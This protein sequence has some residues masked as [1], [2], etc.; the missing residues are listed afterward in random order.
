MS[1]F[2]IHH[3]V[4]AWVLAILITFAGALSLLRLPLE[5]YP[6][7]APPQVSVAARYNGASADTV[8]DSVTQINEQQMK[9]LDGLMY[10][11]SCAES[12][13]QPRTTPTFEPGSDT[14]VAQEQVQNALQQA[15][16]RLPDEVQQ[17]GV[18]VTKGGQENLVT[19]MFVPQEADV[20]RVAITDYLASNLV[21]VLGRIDGVA[22]V[23]L[24]GSPYAMR[25]WLD[26]YKLEQYQLMP[27]DVRSAIERQNV[28]VSAGQLGQLPSVAG[29]MLNVPIQARG[30]LQT[31]A[32]FE[33]IILKSSGSGARSPS[34]LK[35]AS[36][37]IILLEAGLAASN[38]S[39]AA[40]SLCG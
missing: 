19:W 14:D 3:P 11:R 2:F 39:S 35:T 29:Q 4:F 1:R 37:T 32:Q 27:A 28:Q 38:F 25:I 13:G 36:V 23:V 18:N 26:P 9:G 40:M 17:R 12:S 22:E 21:D 8:N 24:Y 20:P 30:K 10:M 33:N 16:S 7:V 15:M 34:M 5:Q 31:A 6:D